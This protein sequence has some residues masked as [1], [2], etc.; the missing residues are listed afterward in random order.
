MKKIVAFLCSLCL[1]FAISGEFLHICASPFVESPSIDIGPTLTEEITIND[2]NGNLITKI[3]MESIIITP[4]E[5]AENAQNADITASLMTAYSF[6]TNSDDMSDVYKEMTTLYG[7]A[8]NSDN[9][10]VLDLVNIYISSEYYS[11]ADNSDNHIVA[12]FK[13]DLSQDKPLYVLFFDK[14]NNCTVVAP[15]N[16]QRN[17]DGTVTIKIDS[18]GTVA[19]LTEK[20][21]AIEA[22]EATEA[23]EADLSN[24]DVSS[25]NATNKESNNYLTIILIAVSGVVLISLIIIFIIFGKKRKNAKE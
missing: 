19:F 25:A 2:F 5:K 14:N 20:A 17:D 23:T 15:E 8:L 7:K 16:I 11:Y 22:T 1:I 13:I 12:T 18:I 21:E 4:M 9:T 6:I 10:A 24:P 3:P